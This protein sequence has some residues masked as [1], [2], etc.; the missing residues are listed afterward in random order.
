MTMADMDEKRVV[1]APTVVEDMQEK[2]NI[3]DDIIQGQ[4][5]DFAVE[6]D[7]VKTHPQP[8]SDPLDPLNW[9]SLKKHGILSIVMFKYVFAL[10]ACPN[11]NV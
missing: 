3:K 1:E 7:G 6:K 11:R 9:S 2:E 10:L 4:T 8:T 5:Y